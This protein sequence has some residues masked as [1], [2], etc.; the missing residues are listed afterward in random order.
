MF[1]LF[2]RALL[3]QFCQLFHRN[4]SLEIVSENRQKD[5][6]C[7]FGPLGGLFSKGFI[8]AVPDAI[9]KQK[10]NPLSRGKLLYPFGR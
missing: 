5:N 9:I 10:G 3:Y 2:F 1:L 7:R 6:T 8:C 4:H